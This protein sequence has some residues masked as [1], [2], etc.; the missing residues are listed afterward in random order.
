MPNIDFIPSELEN[1]TGKI[2]VNEKFETNIP[3]FAIGDAEY[4]ISSIRQIETSTP[5]G[6]AT[7]TLMMLAKH[8]NWQTSQLARASENFCV[9]VLRFKVCSNRF[10]ARGSLKFG[11]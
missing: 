7:A 2:L 11:I 10:D 8:L 6:D 5:F 9:F 1:S 4:S 3:T